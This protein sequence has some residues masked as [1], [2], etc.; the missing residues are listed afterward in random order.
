VLEKQGPPVD[1][2]RVID[3]VA[4][5]SGPERLTASL[6]KR[7]EKLLVR[8]EHP[9]PQTVLAQLALA[10][11]R[12]YRIPEPTAEDNLAD[13]LVWRVWCVAEQAARHQEQS[14]L[15]LPTW[16]DGR[17]DP[18]DLARRIERQP[19][20]IKA[21]AADRASLFHLDLIQ[22]RLRAGADLDR[23]PQPQLTWNKKTWVASGQ[24]YSHHRLALEVPESPKRSRFNP[25]LLSTATF[26]ASLPM[27]RWCAS[28]CPAWREGWFAAGCHDL[29]YNLDWWE[30]NW[31]T[32]AYLETLV[33]P[34]TMIG[35]VGGLLLALGLGAKEAGESMLAVDALISSIA[36]GRLS[37]AVLSRALIQAASSGAIKFARWSKQLGRAAKAGIPQATAIFGAVEAFFESGQQTEAADYFK[38]VELQRELAHQTGL[39]LS[40][41]GAIKTL[42]TIPTGGKT[43]RVIAELLAIKDEARAT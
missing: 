36:E 29:A 12:G 38:L 23:V 25:V 7:A 43:K 19:D 31:S 40:R 15:S 6:A 1:I 8:R 39:R 17:I 22:A 41:P 18:T 30:A 2:E 32:R 26:R 20:D 42:E 35:P 33:E 11:A 14:L 37:D 34:H 21:V 10:W 24:T 16:S 4:R 28:V 5:M 9:Q 13:F 3:G 27:K